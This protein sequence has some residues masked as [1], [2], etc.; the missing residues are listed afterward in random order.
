MAYVVAK[1]RN[2]Q[3]IAKEGDT[4]ELDRVE[5]P[6]DVDVLLYS[7]GKKVLVGTPTVSGVKVK[8][9]VVEDKDAPK[10]R[11]ARFKSKSRYRRV[12]GHKQPVSIVK[13]EKISVGGSTTAAKPAK[14][15][16]EGATK[17]KKTT[18]KEAK[19]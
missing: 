2:T 10:I 13:I 7:D 14:K 1:I 17:A 5:A 16:A 8:A 11:V 19:S 18:K 12:K 9:S 3:F 6:V 15:S 4:I